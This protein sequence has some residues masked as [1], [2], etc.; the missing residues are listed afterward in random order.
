MSAT[1]AL[2]SRGRGRRR[3]CYWCPKQPRSRRPHRHRPSLLADTRGHEAEPASH[4]R[5]STNAGPDPHI[6]KHL[7]VANSESRR[8]VTWGDAARV[9]V[10]LRRVG[11]CLRE[12]VARW[13]G[14]Q[15]NWAWMRFDTPIAA[16]DF[17]V[18]AGPAGRGHVGTQFSV[19]MGG[20][21]LARVCRRS[22]GTGALA[23]RSP[24]VFRAGALAVAP[25]ALSALA[26]GAAPRARLRSGC[27]RR[28]AVRLQRRNRGC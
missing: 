10:L 7:L 12:G 3:R 27:A 4:A 11:G 24:R 8:A 6:A 28:A 23:R 9:V 16:R 2:R 14:C 26:P 1:R 17:D 25:D 20:A 13:H 22:R 18:D 5:A 15:R 21:P 19:A